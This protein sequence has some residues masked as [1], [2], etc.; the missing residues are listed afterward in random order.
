MSNITVSRPAGAALL[1]KLTQ[2]LFDTNILQ[3]G[4]APVPLQFF[5][6]P[7]GGAMPV[8]AVAKTLCDTNMTQA[9]QLGMPQMFDLEGF[10]F[11]YFIHANADLANIATD[12]FFLYEQ[13]VFTFFFGQARPWL[14]VPLSQIPT[15]T[16]LTGTNSDGDITANTE[17]TWLHNGHAS[18]KSLYRF[19]VGKKAI[20]VQSA[21]SFYAQITWPNGVGAFTWGVANSRVRTY[22]VGSLYAAL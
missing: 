9:A 16:A 6:I 8:T 10:Q 11:E 18:V 2:P 3:N 19:T 12:I 20:R 17:A 15:G 22:M 1:R 13:S 5:Q 7:F 14:E 21:E 4:A